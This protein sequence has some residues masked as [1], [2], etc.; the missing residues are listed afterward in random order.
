[1]ITLA[2]IDALSGRRLGAV[3]VPCP[4]C[5]LLRRSARNRRDLPFGVA[6]DIAGEDRSIEG[7][8]S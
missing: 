8:A 3:D 7:G 2:E 4:L 1:M 5:G 6:I